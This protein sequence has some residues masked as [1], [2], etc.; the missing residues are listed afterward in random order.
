MDTLFCKYSLP[1]CLSTSLHPTFSL[2]S[3]SLGFAVCLS[4]FQHFIILYISM[5]LCSSFPC[6][7]TFIRIY[8]LRSL[9]CLFLRF[10]TFS[11]AV[12]KVCSLLCLLSRCESLRFCMFSSLKL[13]VSHVLFISES[14]LFCGICKIGYYSVS[15]RQA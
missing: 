8:S 10:C 9:L 2:H 4:T 5:F 14:C 15:L 3:L 7:A 13:H 11:L 1:M 6:I 12:F